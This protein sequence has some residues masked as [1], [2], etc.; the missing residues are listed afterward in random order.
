MKNEKRAQK[1]NKNTDQN[2]GQNTRRGWKQNKK[3]Q[4]R[5]DH[6]LKNLFFDDEKDKRPKWKIKQKTVEM[7]PGNCWR[8]G[9][10]KTS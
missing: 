10:N 9:K 8:T 5:R 3:K 7:M 2:T 6:E 4:F 1:L